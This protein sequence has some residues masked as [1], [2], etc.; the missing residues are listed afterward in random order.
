MKN[1]I[2]ALKF[3]KE[4]HTV[5]KSPY[6]SSVVATYN[7]HDDVV[8]DMRVLPSMGCVRALLRWVE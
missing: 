4:P 3:K 5:G 2:S 6:T 8:L 1:Q 7:G